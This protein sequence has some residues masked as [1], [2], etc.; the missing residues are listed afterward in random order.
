MECVQ[1]FILAFIVLLQWYR[2]RVRMHFCRRLNGHCFR[3]DSMTLVSF[4]W[5]DRREKKLCYNGHVKHHKRMFLMNTH[6]QRKI[7]SVQQ[8][9]DAVND[10]QRSRIILFAFMSGDKTFDTFQKRVI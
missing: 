8:L 9:F 2:F 10:S 4:Q 3:F 6:F 7:L 5:A 1:I